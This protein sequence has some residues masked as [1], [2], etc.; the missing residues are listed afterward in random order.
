M[1]RKAAEQHKIRSEQNRGNA[2]R[3]EKHAELSREAEAR[4]REK[5]PQKAALDKAFGPAKKPAKAQPARQ[6]KKGKNSVASAI[7]E[8]DYA[9]TPMNLPTRQDKAKARLDAIR[10]ARTS[11]LDF[12]QL[13]MPDPKHPQNATRSLYKPS[14]HH[15]V[16]AEQLEELHDGYKTRVIL[17]CPP[18]HG[19]T[20]L[21]TIGYVA[22]FIGR[23]PHKS[24]IVGTYNSEYAEDI[25]R[26]VRQFIQS[27]TF[28]QIFPGV[29][30]LNDSRAA[31]RLKTK[32]GGQAI[33]VGRGGAVTGRGGDLL[34][35]DDPLKD[36]AEAASPTI[37]Q[38]QW[39]WFN[40]T[41][42]TRGM[43]DKVRVQLIQCMTGDTPVLRPDGLETPLRDIRPGDRVASYDR[44]T[45]QIVTETVLNH[46]NQGADRIFAIRMKSGRVVRANARHPFLVVGQ[47]GSEQ[48]QRT[49]TLRPGQSI[50]RVIGGSIAERPARQTGATA[51]RNARASARRT[52][53][54]IAGLGASA[55]RRPTL[56]ADVQRIF[57]IAMGLICWTTSAFWPRRVGSALSAGAT[58]TPG[59]PPNIGGRSYAWTIATTPE[60]S[61]GFSATSATLSFGAP[62]TPR[63][64]KR[65]RI[66]SDEIVEVVPAGVEDVFDI[67]VSRTENFIANGFV[68]HNTRWHEDDLIGRLTD[69]KNPDYSESE[70]QL[71][72]KIDMPAL[73]TDPDN[74]PL[75]RDF[76][77]ALWPQ[78]F[79]KLYLQGLRQ[80]DPLGFSALYQC[81]P[82]P[83][84]GILFT[85]ECLQTYQRGEL[86]TNLRV[87]MASDHAVSTAQQRDKTCIVAAGVDPE[88]TIWILPDIFWRQ[89]SADQ[90]VDGMLHMIQT[91]K[92]LIW[93]AEGG[94]IGRSLGPFLRKRMQ[95]ES[96]YCAIHEVTPAAD[97]LTRAQAIHGRAMMGRVR[98]PSFAPW[99]GE[100]R[101]ELMKF[102]TGTHD[103]F[104][105]AISHLGRGLT[106]MVGASDNTDKPTSAEGPKVGTLA[107]VKEQARKEAEEAR[108]S[109]WNG[110]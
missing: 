61:V 91:H 49:D 57:A 87:Y 32:A 89:A 60:R 3:R 74:D 66:T 97:K 106:Q 36:A 109:G 107:W 19:K 71:W 16:I 82:A 103:D 48:W 46:V 47:D 38:T 50:R 53:T 51:L 95:E 44:E 18:R 99:W 20:Q 77:D 28:R 30:L 12:M 5:D 27:N 110:W 94:S 78:R 104:V 72:H 13:M 55:L 22:W 41:F 34:I 88:G 43:T 84:E 69:P 24:V 93:W 11:L 70:A 7:P 35:I 64:S 59:G 15:Q 39:E 54:R 42:M 65:Q 9:W 101:D 52:T 96:I 29:E 21:A 102:P 100:A 56:A 92:P 4:A 10:R 98:F 83:P 26:Q 17:T 81:S 40:K 63:P 2:R 108:L 8:C 85:Q 79:S 68:S 73:C 25:G 1:P 86:P 105:D 23:N 90:V 62:T 58:L 45:G 6:L 80:R 75:G 76:G 14:Y 37:R 67:Q 31:D 33:F